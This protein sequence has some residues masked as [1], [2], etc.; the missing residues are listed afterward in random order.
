MPD[1]KESPAALY[2]RW[3]AESARKIR[4]GDRPPGNRSEATRRAAA[5]R[6]RIRLAESAAFPGVAETASP[7]ARVLGVVKRDGYNIERLIF[8]TQTGV[9]ATANAY[10]P[11]SGSGRYPAV[12]NV[13]GH[14]AGARMDPVVQSRCI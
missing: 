14:W 7:D 5:I 10:V 11:T 4:A 8:Q 3:L 9:Y 2:Q 13:H 12:L 6:A 1:A